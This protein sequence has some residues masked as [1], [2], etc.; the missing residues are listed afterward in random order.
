METKRRNRIV[1]ALNEKFAFL[2]NNF[3]VKETYAKIVVWKPYKALSCFVYDWSYTPLKRREVQEALS[4]GPKKLI[5]NNA[6]TE[7][8]SVS[9]K[10]VSSLSKEEENEFTEKSH[11]AFVVN[12][13]LARTTANKK[14]KSVEV[15]WRQYRSEV[16]PSPNEFSLEQLRSRLLV[17]LR[18]IKKIH[19]I[20]TLPKSEEKVS[21]NF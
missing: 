1:E 5:K 15:L 3:D 21:F 11:R 2:I 14:N 7:N 19:H 18:E 20:K 17:A 4:I 6:A 12:L 10:S 13:K 8:V 9:E 16:G